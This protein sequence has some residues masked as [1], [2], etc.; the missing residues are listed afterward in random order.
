MDTPES[1]KPVRELHTERMII[2]AIDPD[3]DAEDIHEWYSL[4]EPMKFTTQ[5]PKKDVSETRAMLA[6][7]NSLPHCLLYAMTI[8]HPDP[9]KKD[10]RKVIGRVGSKS[11]PEIGYSMNPVFQHKGYMTE[12][13]T[14][15]V[16]ELF[17]VMPTA[18]K[19]G[20][21]H[22]IAMTDVEH[23]ASMAVLVRCGFA[24]GRVIPGEYTSPQ[25]GVRDAQTWYVARPGTELPKGLLEGELGEDMDGERPVPDVQ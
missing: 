7:R 3:Q 6:K 19:G 16:P 23:A 20:F 13:L 5:G 8:P 2:R 21:D 1:N 18:E 4:A 11:F 22:A 17:N 12:A 25:L 14:A 24:K 15:F 9:S 10:Q